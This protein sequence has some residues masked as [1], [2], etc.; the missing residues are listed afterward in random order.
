MLQMLVEVEMEMEIGMGIKRGTRR[1][2]AEM[3]MLVAI[4]QG[5]DDRIKIRSDHT[6][7]TTTTIRTIQTSTIHPTKIN[8]S[9]KLYQCHP[10]ACKLP[11]LPISSMLRHRK[12]RE[13]LLHR[14]MPSNTSQQRGV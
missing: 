8:P 4:L 9:R 5:V 6:T 10:L 14:P 12:E 13:S 2:A 1:M 7:I 3:G 11:T